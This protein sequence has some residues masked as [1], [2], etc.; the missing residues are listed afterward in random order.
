[1]IVTDLEYRIQSWNR[2]AEII[3]GWRTAEAQGQVVVGLLH[4]RFQSKGNLQQ[5]S[6][7]FLAKGHWTGEVVQTRKNGEDVYV[8]SSVSL[9]K[10]EHGAPFGI[11]AV[12][13]DITEKRKA[14]EALKRYT[15]EI[16]DLYNNAPAGYHALDTY[17]LITRMNDTELLW[18][19]YTRDEIIGVRRL[20]ELL[21]FPPATRP[22]ASTI[23]SSKIAAG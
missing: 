21:T 1:M 22:L 4:T 18:L 8:Q 14:E 7:D 12:N 9:T 16:E 20:P 11:V 6:G 15:A 13:R 5:I 2:A 23:P 17:G 10:D 3:Y 19:G